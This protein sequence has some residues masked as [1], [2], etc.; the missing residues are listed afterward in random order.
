MKRNLVLLAS[1]MILFPLVGCGGES[2]DNA[3]NSDNIEN[4]DSNT[5]DLT[6]EEPELTFDDSDS[7][8]EDVARQERID[9]LNDTCRELAIQNGQNPGIVCS[10]DPT[11]EAILS[12]PF[13]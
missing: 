2:S 9:D 13:E 6:S 7:V 11:T 5:A 10:D 8:S 1:L 4:S 3:G 12:D